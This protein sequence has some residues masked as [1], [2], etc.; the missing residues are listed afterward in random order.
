MVMLAAATRF[1]RRAT[2]FV[3]WAGGKG[4]LL[5]QLEPL[6]PDR[7]D[8]YLEPFLGG[9]A[10]YLALEPARA[11]LADCNEDLIATYRVIRDRLDDLLAELDTHRHEEAYYYDVRAQRPDA[12]SPVGRAA[13]FIY[14]NKSCY[15]GLY[16]VNRSGHFNVPFG[17]YRTAPRLYSE[18]NLRRVAALLACADLALAPYQQTL[19][20]ARPG[21]FVY[22][23]PPYH[24]LS[25]TASF[26]A[27]TAAA[28][29]A[30]DQRELAR[31]YRL[32]DRRGCR[33]MLSNSSAPLIRELYADF[34]IVE[35]QAHRMINSNAGAR[36]AI[37]ELVVLNY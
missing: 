27:Y 6:L 32:L 33:L 26:T 9:G 8:A 10:F 18:A 1:R 12:L 19:D 13:R 23:D 36:G 24:P 20:R 11:I 3:K 5:D 17:R 37:T 4:Q 14:L 22:V 28:F 7:F 35:V 30:A 29:D 16:R 21:D 15:N 31:W 25:A 34:R 2:P